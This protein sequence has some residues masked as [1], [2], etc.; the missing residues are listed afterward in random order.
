MADRLKWDVEGRDWPLRASSRFV[1]AG[2][3]RWHVQQFGEGPSALLVHGTGASTHSWRGL[4]PLLARHYRVT[5]MDLPGHAFTERLPRGVASLPAVA[6]AIQELLTRLEIAPDVVIGHSAGAAILARMVVDHAIQPQAFVSI[7]GAFLPLPGVPGAIWLPLARL[8]AANSIAARLFTWRTTDLAAVE[9]LVM[10]TGSRIDREGI[11]FYGRLVRSRHHVTG[12]LQMMAGW[13]LTALQPD[14]GRLAVPVLLLAAS[15]DRTVPPS[16][17]ERVAGLVPDA[18]LVHLDDLGH[19]AHEERPD[20]VA[21]RI[22]DFIDPL[23]G[24]A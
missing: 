3:L 19:L 22:R 4:A 20:E 7:N 9:R 2:G 24:R 18:R 21:R 11:E 15:G 17:S 14:L 1:E 8:L 5:S 16:E 10:S 6:R 12:T 23:L 13:E